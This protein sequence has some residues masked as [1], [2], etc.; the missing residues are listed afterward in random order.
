[1]RLSAFILVMFILA[2]CSNDASEIARMKKT[3]SQTEYVIDSLLTDSSAFKKYKLEKMQIR[4]E[5]NGNYFFVNAP[6]EFERY[7]GTWDIGKNPE[8]ATF[9]FKTKNGEIHEN[10]FL[11]LMIDDLRIC[12]K[13]KE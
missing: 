11:C 7:E 4:L 9:R 5:E 6:T 2:S 3:L 10:G 8:T 1:M 13:A 12:F